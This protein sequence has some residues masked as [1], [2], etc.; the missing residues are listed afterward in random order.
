RRRDDRSAPLVHDDARGRKA[1]FGN[2][3]LVR[4]GNVSR[5]DGDPRGVPGADRQPSNLTRIEPRRHCTT[6]RAILMGGLSVRGIRL[7][8]PLRSARYI[9]PLSKKRNNMSFA[10]L[11]LS[12]EL[13]R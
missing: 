7:K 5:V 6:L 12:A 13:V 4:A 2:D 10:N 11:G 3:H 8:I 1:E 9:G